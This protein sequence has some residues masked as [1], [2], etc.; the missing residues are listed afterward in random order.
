[1]VDY[2]QYIMGP[3]QYD[4]Q[5]RAQGFEAKNKKKLHMKILKYISLKHN[6]FIKL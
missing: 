5:S 6:S 2:R 3:I 1:M 4:C